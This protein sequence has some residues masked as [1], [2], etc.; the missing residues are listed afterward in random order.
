MLPK[1]L[2]AIHYKG[3]RKHS[4]LPEAYC[5]S[6]VFT[7]YYL[8]VLKKFILIGI[9]LLLTLTYEAKTCFKGL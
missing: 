7:C 1:F 2:K 3:F 5:K 6:T 4:K 9:V 8:N